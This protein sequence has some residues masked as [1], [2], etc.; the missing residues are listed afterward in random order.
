[1][2]VVSSPLT[3]WPLAAAVL[4]FLLLPCLFGPSS[5][6]TTFYCHAAEIG[7]PH[8]T[9]VDLTAD[10]FDDH[11]SDPA[12]GLW[13]LKFYAPWC[14]HCKQLAPTLDKVAPFLSGKMSFGKIDCTREKKLC[15]RFDVR[16]YPTL[17]I[18]RDGD[19]FPYPGKRD[20]DSI[21]DFGERMARHAIAAVGAYEEA[22]DVVA[23]GGDDGVGFVAY[24]PDARGDTLE[25]VVQSTKYLQV[26]HQAAR[27]LQAEATFGVLMPAKK[28]DDAAG[29]GAISEGMLAQFGTPANGQVLANGQR[30]ITKLE[31]DADGKFFNPPHEIN[32]VDLV[33]YVREHNK[34]LVTELGPHNFRAIGDR[35]MPVAIAVTDPDRAEKSDALVAELR[36]YAKDGQPAS[37]RYRF[38]Y[39]KMDGKRWAK[40]LGQFSIE[41]GNLPEL[42]V[43]DISN[44][45]YWQ[46]STVVGVENFLKAVVEGKIQ[47]RDQEGQG[48]PYL[49]KIERLFIDHMPMSVFVVLAFFMVPMI[50]LLFGAADDEE[51]YMYEE[52]KATAG[53][54]GS[55]GGDG[56]GEKKVEEEAEETKKEK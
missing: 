46:N 33:K 15:G 38:I 51:D 47:E 54:C 32:T 14:G 22:L 45:K 43:L 49:K 2:M 18:F 26:F 17:Q 16:G 27:K 53:G 10:T 29:G 37:V 1:M 23:D 30:F 21:I 7:T 39:A 4:C 34:A 28:G 52:E 24:D 40:F 13:F 11:L 35:Q 31:R 44:K 36:Q 56:D 42:F 48:N 6:S 9:V 8:S 20:A 3:S 41:Q 50:Y 25:E 19:Y 5:S 55:K 12:N